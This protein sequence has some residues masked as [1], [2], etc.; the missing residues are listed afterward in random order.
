MKRTT[1]NWFLSFLHF[2]LMLAVLSGQRGKAADDTKTPRP[3]RVIEL[4]PDDVTTMVGDRGELA[5]GLKSAIAVSGFGSPQDAVTW[6]AI[7]P[8]EDDYAVSVIFSAK[9]QEKIEVHCGESVVTTSSLPKTWEDR[10]FYWRQELPGLL[11]LKAGANRI[12]FR[13]PE[14]KQEKTS[15]PGARGRG[16][17]KPAKPGS[18]ATEE[19]SLWSIELGTPAA[20]NAQLAR[21]KEIRGDTS[22]MIA[23]KYGLFVHWSPLGYPLHGDQPRAQWHQKAVEMFDVKVFADAVERT[24]AAWMIFTM[25]HGKF[26][27]PGPSEALDK[28]LPGR[29]TRRDLIGE[30]IAELDRRGIRTLFYLHNGASGNEDPEWSKAVG[31]Q[32]AD[33]KRFGDNIEAILRESSLR[34]GKKLAGYGYI[35]CSF[36]NDYPLDPPWERWARVIKAGNPAAVVGFSSQRGP[37]VSPFSELAVTDG[38]TALG[39]PNLAL[40]GPGRQLGEVTPT[41]WFAM[42]RWI[43]KGPMNGTI[44]KGPRFSAVEYVGHFQQLA[45]AKIPLTINMIITADVTGEHPIFNERCTAVMDQVRKAIRGK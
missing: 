40:I 39:K 11:H 19:F 17:G 34:Y 25:T 42:D 1:E 35:D 23:G 9:E 13:L 22:W 21:A 3:A 10:P 4:R 20:R 27:W 16:K 6:T 12:T 26:Y 36:A 2:C 44:G 18:Q 28:I 24:G 31:A 15:E 33:L 7:A 32:D 37:T 8:K 14:A 29:T 43:F 45:A 38:G 5:G 30:T 41:W